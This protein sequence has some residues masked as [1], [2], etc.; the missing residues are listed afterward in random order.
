[1]RHPKQQGEDSVSE[2]DMG[3]EV[4]VGDRVGWKHLAMKVNVKSRS[5][6]DL[7]LVKNVGA[8]VVFGFAPTPFGNEVSH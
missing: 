1:M 8:R 2:L 3:C 5:G 7:L 6:I 4:V